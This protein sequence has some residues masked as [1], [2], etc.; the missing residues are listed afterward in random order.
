MHEA[1]APERQIL[2][3]KL[4]AEEVLNQLAI[5]ESRLTKTRRDLINTAN[6]PNM[7]PKR[8]MAMVEAYNLSE[9]IALAIWK[10]HTEA[11]PGILTRYGLALSNRY[12]G[13]EE[14][15]QE[16]N[17]DYLS[18]LYSKQERK[19][20]DKDDIHEWQLLL[21]CQADKPHIQS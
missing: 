10:I 14:R 9:E 6:D 7:D 16:E 21:V 19:Q 18:L 12:D 3:T 17:E 2:A 13:E 11:A 1:F 5:L 15:R 8:L 4:I 20:Q